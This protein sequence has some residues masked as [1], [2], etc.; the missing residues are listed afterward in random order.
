M[1]L[2]SVPANAPTVVSRSDGIEQRTEIHRAS[3]ERSSK[4]IDTRDPEPRSVERGG[5]RIALTSEGTRGDIE[6]LLSLA[7]RF[8]ERG[9]EAFLCASPDFAK[10]AASKAARISRHRTQC[11]RT[12]ARASQSGVAAVV[13][14]G[15]AGTTTAAA[16]AGVPQILVPHLLDQHYWA[17]RVQRL[18]IGAP[19]IRHRR[20]SADVLAD[21]ISA[22]LDNELVAEGAQVLGRRLRE[23]MGTDPTVAFLA[24]GSA[25]EGSGRTSWSL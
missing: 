2:K 4:P 3:L 7:E 24:N 11:P 15:G 12:R 16:R 13:H 14:H 9:H 20:L 23:S 6:P 19:P 5:L 25:P 1:P 18:G 17:Q 10:T 21:T 8:R 22:T